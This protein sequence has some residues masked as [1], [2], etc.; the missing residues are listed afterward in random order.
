MT[1]EEFD[2]AITLMGVSVSQ[3][4]HGHITIRLPSGNTIMVADFMYDDIELQTTFNY[5]C[6][7]CE[8]V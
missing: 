2:A 3:P 8:R 6:K 4:D 1:R 7:Y 5:I